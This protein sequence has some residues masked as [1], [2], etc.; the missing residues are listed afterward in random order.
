M[1]TWRTRPLFDLSTTEALIKVHGL[2]ILTPLA[3]IEGP[4][5]TV[6]AAYLARIGYFSL[7]TV[8]VVV[9]VADLVGD[10]LFYMVGRRL[11]ST[12]KPPPKWIQRFGVTENRIQT[13]VQKFETEGGKL[14]VMGK[15]THSAGAAVL[16]GAGIARMRFLPFMIYSTISTIPKSL[17]F[18]AI[19]YAFGDL[20]DQ[21]DGWI[22][23][24]SIVL[25]VVIVLLGIRWLKKAS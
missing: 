6:I 24:I 2:L 8:T 18:I 9:V 16:L 7:M 20:A 21:V 3:I 4:I 14:I 19:G 1:K 15:L 22:A 23:I 13:M 17:L 25:L 5:V 11:L 12:E 10:V